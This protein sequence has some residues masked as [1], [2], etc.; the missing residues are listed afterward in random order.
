MLFVETNLEGIHGILDLRSSVGLWFMR[1]LIEYVLPIIAKMPVDMATNLYVRTVH[2]GL[3]RSLHQQSQLIGRHVSDCERTIGG[4]KQLDPSLSSTTECS[5]LNWHISADI[6]CVTV[7]VKFSLCCALCMH[8]T[9]SLLSVS[10]IDSG[11]KFIDLM[12]KVA[13]S[14]LPAFK[15]SGLAAVRTHLSE[16]QRASYQ[17]IAIRDQ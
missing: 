4:S 16:L 13:H 2:V 10:D 7:L 11:N 14:A 3:N 8:L 9:T 6:Q 12:P 17:T 15:I 1:T 5:C